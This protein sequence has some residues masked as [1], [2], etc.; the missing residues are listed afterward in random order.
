MTEI[1]KIDPHTLAEM[2]EFEKLTFN[3]ESNFVQKIRRQSVQNKPF[4]PFGQFGPPVGPFDP[5]EWKVQYDKKKNELLD[6]YQQKFTI[7][8]Y[9]K[10]FIEYVLAGEIMPYGKKETIEAKLAELNFPK[11]DTVPKSA[12][13]DREKAIGGRASYQ[14]LF[15]IRLSELT[16]EFCSIIDEKLHDKYIEYSVLRKIKTSRMVWDDCETQKDILA[17]QIAFLRGHL[18]CTPYHDG[19][20]YPDTKLHLDQLVKI[21][22]NG[23]FTMD[24]QDGHG[25]DDIDRHHTN[26]YG[27][28]YL[29]GLMRK[30]LV[31]QF[32]RHFLEKFGDDYYVVLNRY[33]CFSRSKV[34]WKQGEECGC[35]V[36]ND[37]DTVIDIVDFFD[38]YEGVMT[39]EF[40][41]LKKLEVVATIISLIVPSQPPESDG[42]CKIN[43]ILGEGYYS[44][45]II[46]NKT[47]ISS[48][49]DDVCGILCSIN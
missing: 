43:D 14:Y 17:C 28:G 31:P 11:I 39:I 46:R 35:A 25:K 36:W 32:V 7:L 48:I 18:D 27:F 30:V 15:D 3:I 1:T 4:G 2:Q 29:S 40:N 10:I 8:D 38:D 26:I 49:M 21:N 34:V 45:D 44:V 6:S 42:M 12:S 41:S 5:V 23:F 37:E 13:I 16:P 9:Q 20:I 47:G 19:P 33:Y 22:Q 24:S